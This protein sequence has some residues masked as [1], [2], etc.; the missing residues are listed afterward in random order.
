[1]T[2]SVY[3][4]F[5]FDC[6]EPYPYPDAQCYPYLTIRGLKREFKTW[7]EERGLQNVRA[8]KEK[9]AEAMATIYGNSERY[10]WSRVQFKEQMIIRRGKDPPC[11][12]FYKHMTRMNNQEQ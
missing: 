7:R 11:P 6:I 10:E 4:Q 3:D 1:M 9:L 2:D 5:I 8:T 12:E